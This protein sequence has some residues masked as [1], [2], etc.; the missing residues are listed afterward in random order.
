MILTTAQ[1]NAVINAMA[2][3]NNVGCDRIQLD[4]G[5]I[6]VDGSDGMVSILQNDRPNGLIRI[7]REYY[8]TQADFAAAYG[9]E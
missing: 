5:A 8:D 4:I 3:L 2:H 6:L 9:L 1:A 7:A